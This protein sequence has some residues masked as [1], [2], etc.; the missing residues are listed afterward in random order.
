MPQVQALADH[1]QT[2][3]DVRRAAS[4]VLQRRRA[5]AGSFELIKMPTRARVVEKPKTVIVPLG[6]LVLCGVVGANFG[7]QPSFPERAPR[8]ILQEIKGVVCAQGGVRVADIDS[9]QRTASIVVA[10]HIAMMLCR[11]LTHRSLPDIGRR[12]GG[13]DHTTVI[14]ALDKMQPVMDAIKDQVGKIP[15][16][17]LVAL[18]FRTY[19]EIKPKSPRRGRRVPINM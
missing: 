19:W 17:D 18:A 9:E 15:L 11:M 1:C 16:R 6:S 2:A 10:R 4:G 5:M 3:E 7:L 13:R 14:H 8:P 12:F